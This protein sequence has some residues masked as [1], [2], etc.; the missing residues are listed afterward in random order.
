MDKAVI[1]RI[2]TDGRLDLRDEVSHLRD[3]VSHLRDEVSHLRDEVSTTRVSGWD[4]RST[5]ALSV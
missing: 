2:L 5:C 3:E 4:H 1:C